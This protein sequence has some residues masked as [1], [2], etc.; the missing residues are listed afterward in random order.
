MANTANETPRM[1]YLAFE[2]QNGRY[3]Q[4]GGLSAEAAR[5]DAE[6]LASSKTKRSVSRAEWLV[7]SSILSQSDPLIPQIIA[8]VEKGHSVWHACSLVTGQR[9]FCAAC[10]PQPGWVS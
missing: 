2:M 6:R 8:E 5:W 1:L 4:G 7:R 3:V 9:C 10:N